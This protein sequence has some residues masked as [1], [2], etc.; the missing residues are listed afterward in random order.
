[1]QYSICLQDI[2]S[3]SNTFCHALGHF[4]RTL[5]NVRRL[6]LALDIQFEEFEEIEEFKIRNDE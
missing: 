4:Y 5:S 3:V 6:F 2:A 1:M